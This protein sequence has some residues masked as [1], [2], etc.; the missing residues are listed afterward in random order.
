MPTG[1]QA[2]GIGVTSERADGPID[3]DVPARVEEVEW[4]GEDI[5]IDETSVDGEGAHE[6]DD[7]AAA[8]EESIGT[9]GARSDRRS[10]SQK[11]QPHNLTIG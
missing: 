8:T 10:D 5:V 4:L 1:V 2:E 9:R 11:K 3:R 7:I 6:E